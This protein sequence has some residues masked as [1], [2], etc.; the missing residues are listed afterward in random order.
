MTS[1]EKIDQLIAVLGFLLALTAWYSELMYYFT[2]NMDQNARFEHY[3]G[4]QLG[5]FSK[6]TPLFRAL[7]Q[8]AAIVV[9]IALGLKWCSL[10]WASNWFRTEVLTMRCIK[11]WKK[12]QL[13]R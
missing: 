5:R 13:T 11:K 7:I 4:K 6:T 9:L 10:V 2:K 12:K 3:M 8:G 1:I